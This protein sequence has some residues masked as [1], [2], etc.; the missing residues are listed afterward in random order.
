MMMHTIM[1]KVTGGLGI[2]ALGAGAMLA[3]GAAQADERKGLTTPDGHPLSKVI[4]GYEFR[5]PETQA[6]QD[7]DF[8]NPGMLWVDTGA[9]L[10]DTAAGEA[11][12]S[13]ADCHGDAADSMN[14]AGAHYPK[15]N[16]KAGKAVNLE[17]QINTCRTENQKA[18]AWKWESEPLLSMTSFVR[19]QSRGTPVAVQTDGPMTPVFE[20]GKELY[21]TRNGQ[22]DMACANCHEDNNGNRIRSDMLSQGQSNGFPTYRLKWQKVGSLH[23]RFK[24]CMKQV[25][26][27]PYKVGS[28]EFVALELYLA[29]RGV[30]LPVETPAVRN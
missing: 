22:L 19:H 24:G 1:K 26:A 18:E 3:A 8:Q 15:W 13:C 12:K 29:W 11:N 28:D 6:L 27:T 20:K 17:Q 5:I 23:R 21:Y 10:W 14:E 16:E 30:G 9:E 7:D 25:R 4:S 2:L